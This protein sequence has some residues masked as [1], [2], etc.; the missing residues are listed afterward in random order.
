MGR[1]SQ[2]PP[3]WATEA[4]EA[5]LAGET[6]ASL[7]RRHQASVAMLYTWIDRVVG[8][9]GS[10]R[11]APVPRRRRLAAA[12]S[13]AA[14]S[15]RATLVRRLWRAADAQMCQLE[16]RIA[17][18]DP[19]APPGDAEAKALGLIA[20][21]VRELVALDAAANETAGGHSADDRA[22]SAAERSREGARVAKLRAE[23]AR[24]LAVD[25]DDAAPGSAGAD[26]AAD[27]RDPGP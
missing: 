8:E 12:A 14:R 11:Q 6:L 23:I 7:Q 27:D 1:G 17:A 18:L 20:R 21:I 4:R 3:G 19:Q 2:V 13:P 9:D 15:G 10:I 16:R 26:D 22:L 25:V 5:Y 24:R